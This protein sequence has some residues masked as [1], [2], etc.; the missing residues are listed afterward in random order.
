MRDKTYI[1]RTIKVLL[2]PNEPRIEVKVKVVRKGAPGDSWW[3]LQVLEIKKI[4]QSTGDV[5]SGDPNDLSAIKKNIFWS[6]TP[7]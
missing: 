5:T 6:I 4:D 7:M 1:V 3:V 2:E